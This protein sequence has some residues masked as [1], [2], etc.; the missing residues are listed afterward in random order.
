MNAFAHQ[1]G[2][3]LQ[4]G[5]A[6]LYFEQLGRD[7]GETLV[8]LHG[9][10]GTLEDFNAL[11]PHLA[12]SFRLIA[13]DTRGHGKSTLGS[14]P[15]TYARLEADVLSVTQQ[16]GLQRFS[17][18]GFSDGG[19]VG[20]RLAA[21]AQCDVAKL[22]VLGTPHTLAEDDPLRARLASVTADGWRAKF[23]ETVT[24]YERLNPAPD[25]AALV[26]AVVPLWID[27]TTDGYPGDTVKNI[28]CPVLVAR[29]DDDHLVTRALTFELAEQLAYAQLLNVPFAGHEVHKDQPSIVGSVLERFLRSA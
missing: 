27:P 25:F 5:D 24:F 8:L 19:I 1:D 11:V 29:G 22:V 15:L 10:L 9:G 4:V 7:E 18:I 21:R 13:V 12:P 16:L 6:A 17:L 14:A 20:L 2:R 3:S 23:P 28:G 26:R